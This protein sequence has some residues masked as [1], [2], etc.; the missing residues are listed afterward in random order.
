MQ[1]TSDK[2]N[3]IL[4]STCAEEYISLYVMSY[5]PCAVATITDRESSSVTSNGI[6]SH[7]LLPLSHGSFDRAESHSD[8][9]VLSDSDIQDSI[10]DY[11]PCDSEVVKLKCKVRKLLLYYTM[12][13]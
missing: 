2:A 4:S 9:I 7:Y 8:T 1:F 12:K 10:E 3:A 11:S 5:P 6:E 13:M